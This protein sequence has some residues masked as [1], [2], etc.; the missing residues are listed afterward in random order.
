MGAVQ[1]TTSVT[2]FT[3][4]AKG[5]MAITLLD[6]NASALSVIHE[7]SVLEVAGACF[8][9]DAPETPGTWTTCTTAATAYLTCVPSGSAGSQVL[10]SGWTNVAPAWNDVNAGWYAT[11]GSASRVIAS[12]YKTSNTSQNN[13][14]LLS[15]PM[16]HE[17]R[18]LAINANSTI[19]AD[20]AI[21]T[22]TTFLADGVITAGGGLVAGTG[23]ATLLKKV[24]NIG[25]WNMDTTASVNV[26]HGLTL[27][28][29]YSVSVMIRTDTESLHQMLV[30]TDSSGAIGGWFSTDATN[31]V[32]NRT[33]GGMFDN[34]A[35]DATSYN[36][37]YVVIEYIP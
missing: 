35:L 4:M 15:D 20:G 36:R 25:D 28:K 34:T 17:T 22:D 18:S 8:R 24:V 16:V 31:V 27:A 30:A 6:Y 29:I 33:T 37:G 11:A 21:D 10:T 14:R 2:S 9:W 23:N 12:A 26:A 3:N 13:K 7:G 1:V 19:H 32:C 5:A